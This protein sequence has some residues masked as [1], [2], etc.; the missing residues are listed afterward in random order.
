M[1][2]YSVHRYALMLISANKLK[3][4]STIT[5]ITSAGIQTNPADGFMKPKFTYYPTIAR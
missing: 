5:K 3:L 1:Q 2:R 4:S